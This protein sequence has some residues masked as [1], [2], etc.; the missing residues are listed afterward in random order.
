MG[1]GLELVYT[2]DLIYHGLEA[3]FMRENCDTEYTQPR[4]FPPFLRGGQTPGKLPES[5]VPQRW[6]QDGT[7]DLGR[8]IIRRKRIERQRICWGEIGGGG[9]RCRGNERGGTEHERTCC[10]GTFLSAILFLGRF[11]GALSLP[12]FF[13]SSAGLAVARKCSCRARRTPLGTR[14]LAISMSR[15]SFCGSSTLCHCFISWMVTGCLTTLYAD[16]SLRF[17]PQGLT[18]SI[19]V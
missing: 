10:N 17:A 14:I 8:H 9:I 13:L 6:R 4:N 18:N 3:G 15:S 11:G 16:V 7:L 12:L 5:K 19:T 2:S 1:F